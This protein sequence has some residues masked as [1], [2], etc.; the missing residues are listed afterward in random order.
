MADVVDYLNKHFLADVVDYL[1]KH[2]LAD[3]VYYLNKCFLADVA[4]YLNQH[5]PADMAL[6]LIK[7]LLQYSNKFPMGWLA[8]ECLAL[9][10]TCSP[11]A[12]ARVATRHWQACRLRSLAA[13]TGMDREHSLVTRGATTGP[14]RR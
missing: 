10:R 1:N 5:L 2:F 7:F 12:L 3:V 9:D 6:N 13:L 4:L 8:T 14:P 11:M